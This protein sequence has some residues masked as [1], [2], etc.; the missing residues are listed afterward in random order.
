MTIDVLQDS[1]GMINFLP[2][3]FHQAQNKSTSM[4]KRGREAG[5]ELQHSA[6][7]L[8]SFQIGLPKR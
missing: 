6:S 3:K 4:E 2:I 8:S 7:P 1:I 5:I